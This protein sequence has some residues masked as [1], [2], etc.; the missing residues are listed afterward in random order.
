MWHSQ[1]FVN[2][3][4]TKAQRHWQVTYRLI[5]TT[6]KYNNTMVVI[7][8]LYF[9]IFLNKKT[10][11]CL[12]CSNRLWGYS[13]KYLIALCVWS[14]LLANA[15]YMELLTPETSPF[16]F[17]WT[18]TGTPHTPKRARGEGPSGQGAR[19]KTGLSLSLEVDNTNLCWM[20]AHTSQDHMFSPN[21]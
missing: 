13:G 15:P 10:V 6:F 17:I 4:E 1:A 11:A 19:G 3:L 9:S 20:S 18:R 21:M 5:E 7:I 2:V 12:C 8:G 16:P 14:T